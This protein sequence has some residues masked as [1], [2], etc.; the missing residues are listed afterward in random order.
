VS[1]AQGELS[2]LERGIHALNSG[3]G[4]KAYAATEFFKKIRRITRDS[5]KYLGWR[6]ASGNVSG[7]QHRRR[8]TTF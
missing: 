5:K 3:M 2:P 4:V 6:R 1:N 7:P 8:P